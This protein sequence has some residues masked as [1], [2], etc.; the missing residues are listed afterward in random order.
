MRIVSD[1]LNLPLELHRT[2]PCVLW[3]KYFSEMYTSCTMESWLLIPLGVYPG[4]ILP[5]H[6]MGLHLLRHFNF[7]NF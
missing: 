4:P 6:V 7:Q 1:F 5:C 2:L 3:L